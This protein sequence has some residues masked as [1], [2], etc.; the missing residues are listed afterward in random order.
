MVFLTV[1]STF[2]VEFL[3]LADLVEEVVEGAGDEAPDVVFEALSGL[4]RPEHRERLAASR[5]AAAQGHKIA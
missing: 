5:L 2:S 3:L 1:A 4:R